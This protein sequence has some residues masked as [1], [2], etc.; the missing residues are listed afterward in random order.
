MKKQTIW[1]GISLLILLAMLISS[2]APNAATPTEVVPTQ[3][4]EVEVV[5]TDLPPVEV[6]PTDVIPSEAPPTEVAA[7]A[8]P[9]GEAK[10]EGTLTIRMPSLYEEGFLPW[11]GGSASFLWELVYDYLIYT[12][13]DGSAVGG[14]AERWETSADAISVTAWLRKGVQFQD[15]W[16]EVTAEDVKYTFEK[17]MAEGSTNRAAGQLRDTIDNIE[18]VDPYTIIWHLK[19]PNPTFWMM[20]SDS[21]YKEGPIVSKSYIEKVGEDYAMYNPVG[22]GPWH[23]VGRRFGDFIQFEAQDEHWRVVPEYKTLVLKIIPEGS[24][25]VAMLKTGGVDATDIAASDTADLQAAGFK[26]QT[27]QSGSSL[28][29]V[30]GGMLSSADDRYVEGYH[31]Q[32]PWTDVRVREAMNIAIDRQAIIDA[33]QFG[34]GVPLK[35]VQPYPGSAGLPA[36]P[37]DPERAMQLLADAGY[38]NGFS[39]EVMSYPRE[40]DAPKIIEAVVGYWE[41]I[42]L[43]PQIVMGDWTVYRQENIN[44]MKTAG[45]IWNQSIT[46][47]ADLTSNLQDRFLPNKGYS[48]FIDDNIANL[49]KQLLPEVNLDKRAELWTQVSQALYDNWTGIPIAEFRQTWAFN[50]KI[51]GMWPMLATEPQ[52]LAYIRHSVPLN[53]FRLFELDPALDD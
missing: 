44:T 2:C 24:T 50:D 11:V 48:F 28:Y 15:G 53:T 9:Q 47:K 32:D 16:G 34:A 41:Q 27:V 6:I 1:F 29:L 17:N 8:I 13:L 51:E 20:L 43:Q 46:W 37:Y 5:P 22:S 25:A 49:I 33:I 39:F 31:R 52:N 40:F 42:G 26:V 3:A 14:L 38:P 10:P 30:F 36:I 45:Q 7:T 18:I 12:R 35:L 21:V 23:F 19:A 4:P